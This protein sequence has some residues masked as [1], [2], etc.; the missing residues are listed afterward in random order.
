MSSSSRHR[1][2]V[3]GSVLLAGGLFACGGEKPL[4]NEAT[5]TAAPV[6]T[7]TPAPT[8]SPF[9]G[10][11][12]CNLPPVDSPARTCS[13]ESGGGVFLEQVDATVEEVRA[14]H[15]EY[16]NSDGLLVDYGRFRMAMIAGLEARGLCAVIDQDASSLDE[17]AVKNDNGFSEQ[18]KVELSSRRLRTGGEAYRSTCR[19]ANF[20]INPTPLPQRGDCALPSSRAWAGC[21]RLEDSRFVDAVEKAHDLAIK[22]RSDLTD[23]QTVPREKW[24]DYYDEMLKHLRD[25]G[26]C[27]IFD[28]EEIAV[29]NDNLGSEQFHVIFSSGKLRRGFD[30]YRATCNPAAF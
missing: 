18:W 8:P 6:R 9:P 14:R 5:P 7:E 26:Y 1:V 20:P 28:G 19:P 11:G 24:N 22:T 15:P 17:I 3:F 29:K 23:G 16:F 2:R 30:Q 13:R 27:A 4:S 25:M 12:G 10:V 21:T